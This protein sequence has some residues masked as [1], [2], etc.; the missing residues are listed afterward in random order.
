MT[1]LGFLLAS[2]LAATNAEGASPPPPPRL[3]DP[4]PE[5]PHWSG[6]LAIGA[7][8]T[9]GNSDANSANANFNAQRRTEKDRYTM[10]AFWNRSTQA[11]KKSS[12]PDPFNKDDTELTVG[13]YGAG[14]KYDYF[15]SPKLYYYANGSGKVDHVA[16]LD[17]RLI[18]GGGV[19]YQWKESEKVKWGTEVGLSAVDEDY[20]GNDADADFVAVRL[21]SNLAYQVS[22][23]TSFE[24]VA[25]LLPSLED[26]EDVIAKLDNRLKLNIA[27][28]WIAQ[29]QYVLDFDGSVP[30]GS[31]PGSDG[32]KET[33]H[34]V[35]LAIG[36]D[37]GS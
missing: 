17:L 5:Y 10:D 15:S 27:G 30:A 33:D 9:E 14:L 31:Q 36:W 37:F 22:K 4:P 21:G 18:G 25:E 35:V 29:I 11:G 24:Q 13:N 8:L 23:S 7:L 20:A 6:A 12:N 1:E 32:K 28:K 19:G 26:S 2:L 3:Q 16:D 34:R